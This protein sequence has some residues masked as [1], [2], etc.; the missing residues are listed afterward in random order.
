MRRSYTFIN[1]EDTRCLNSFCCQSTN[2]RQVSTIYFFSVT[3][4]LS[5][6]IKILLELM[7]EP[8]NDI[9]NILIKFTTLMKSQQEIL[10]KRPLSRSENQNDAIL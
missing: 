7:S 5:S 4:P 8:V 10:S 9:Q 6:L 3:V 1:L 2:L